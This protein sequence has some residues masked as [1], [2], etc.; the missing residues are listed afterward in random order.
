MELQPK[1]TNYFV[2]S[3]AGNDNANDN[4]NSIIFT[5]K[6]RNKKQENK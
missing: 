6:D 5:I 1:W 4:D 2:L 3:A